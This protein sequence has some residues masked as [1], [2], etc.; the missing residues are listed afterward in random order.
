MTAR[1]QFVK[2]LDE[3]IAKFSAYAAGAGTMDRCEASRLELLRL[4][5]AACV[6]DADDNEPDDPPLPDFAACQSGAEAIGEIHSGQFRWLL[7]EDDPRYGTGNYKLYTA[8][9]ASGAGKV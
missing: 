7:S 8:P 9:H 6:R 4:F 5:D 2:A 3:C 1:E